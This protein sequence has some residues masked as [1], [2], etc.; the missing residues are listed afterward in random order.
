MMIQEHPPPAAAA[1]ATPL[2][3]FYHHHVGGLSTNTHTHIHTR[4]GHVT[5][6]THVVP[7]LVGISEGGCDRGRHSSSSCM[8]SFVFAVC[9]L[10]PVYVHRA[11]PACGAASPLHYVV[12]C[13]LCVR[14]C[15]S[16]EP[17]EAV[18]CAESGFTV[19]VLVMMSGGE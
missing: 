10:F 2:P 6:D 5:R 4:T 16:F 9:H 13:A 12:L 1:A 7:F 8:G 14:A 15:C 18:R 3:R 11:A 17:V 19:C